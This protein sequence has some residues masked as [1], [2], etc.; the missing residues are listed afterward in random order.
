LVVAFVVRRPLSSLLA[1][2]QP[3]MLL[4]PAAFA[5]NHRPS[6]PPP[7]LPLLPGRHHLHR[8]HCGQTCQ[9]S[10]PKKEA[11]TAA[12]PAYQQQH[13]RENIYKSR[14]LDLFNLSS[15]SREFS[16]I[17]VVSLKKGTFF[18]MYIL[19]DAFSMFLGVA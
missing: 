2:M 14:L 12:P 3:S 5:A 10:L 9:C 6:L 8:H 4:L 11:T 18:A 7:P 19:V 17:Q 16:Y 1:I 15:V 13:Q